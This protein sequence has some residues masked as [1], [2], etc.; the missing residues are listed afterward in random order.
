M[1][2]PAS[3]PSLLAGVR[4]PAL[5]PDDADFAEE[6]AVFKRLPPTVRT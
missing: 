4:G 2:H 6:A 3:T 5:F 1:S